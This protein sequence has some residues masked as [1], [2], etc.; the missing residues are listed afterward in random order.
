VKRLP[1]H[2]DPSNADEAYIAGLLQDVRPFEPSA[3][4]MNRVWSALERAPSQR[5]RIRM[6]GPVIAGLILCG[7]TV[8]SATLPRAWSRWSR[9]SVDV[10]PAVVQVAEKSGPRRVPPPAPLPRAVVPDLASDAAESPAAPPPRTESAARKSTSSKL[11]A[12]SNATPAQ[13][14][15]SPTGGMLMIEAM[16]ERRAGNL[17][18]AL[19]LASA[20]RTQNPGGA[21]DEEALALSLQAAAVLG[22]EEAKPLARLYVQRYP[23]GRFRAQ[24]QR[25][26][27]ST[28]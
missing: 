19:G 18:R 11:N 8:A 2:F 24:A 22:D 3:D 28:H 7:A 23:G 4:Q 20:Y 12:T 21:L 17:A 6:R 1:E 15:D 16:R 26:L 10:T 13:S 14:A 25:V 5:P 9:A 27:D